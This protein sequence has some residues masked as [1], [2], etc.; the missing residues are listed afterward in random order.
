MKL[1]HYLELK[2]KEETSKAE[3]KQ[4][5]V[6]KTF[7]DSKRAQ[8]VGISI[9]K[10]PKIQIISKALLTMDEKALN[11]NNIDAL[12]LIAITKEELDLYKSMGPDGVWEKNEMFLIEL[13]EIPNYLLWG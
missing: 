11:E 2:K 10:L 3:R 9:A 1:F 5:V 8:E 13:N 6:K 12:L 4:T 7:L